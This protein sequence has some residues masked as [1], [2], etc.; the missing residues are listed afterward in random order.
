MRE[1]KISFNYCIDSGF[2]DNTVCSCV[3]KLTK[4]VKTN[5]IWHFR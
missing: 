4:V 5:Q 3:Y 2:S 1:T